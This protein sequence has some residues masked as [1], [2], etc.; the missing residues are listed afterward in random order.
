MF[1]L[2]PNL[3]SELRVKIWQ[4][5]CS[6]RTVTL[7][8]NTTLS[9]F[10]STTTP[11]PLLSVNHESR[12]EALRIYT[13]SFGSTSKPGTTYF[14]PH[15]DTLYLPRCQE[16]GYDETLRD[17]RQLVHDPTNLLDQLKS[18][19]IDHINVDV[20]C[21]WESYNTAIFLRSFKHLDEIKLI[22]NADGTGVG[23]LEYDRDSSHESNKVA[24]HQ[25]IILDELSIAPERLLTIWYY[26]RQSFMMEEQV[27]EDVCRDTDREYE[28]FELPTIRILAKVS[29]AQTKAAKGVDRER[30]TG[31]HMHMQAA[32]DMMRS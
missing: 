3:P 17:F 7:T 5:A 20:K 11:P 28:P 25:N 16:M 2:F 9:S 22:L 18:V 31:Q 29:G 12:H 4:Q 10:K 13:L 32:L 1:S 27:L 15:L 26:F 14:N 19:A 21:P 6:P 30:R 23:D 8:Y 24:L